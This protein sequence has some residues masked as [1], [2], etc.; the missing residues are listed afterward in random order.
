MQNPTKS[1]REEVEELR[2]EQGNRYAALKKAFAQSPAVI[3]RARD[4]REQLLIK[5]GETRLGGLPLRVSTFLPDGPWGHQEYKDDAEAIDDIA[6]RERFVSATPAGDPEVIAWTSTEVFQRG[7]AAASMIQ[8]ENELRYFWR[9]DREPLYAIVNRARELARDGTT[10]AFE[11][12]AT[13][14]QGELRKV[15]REN[16][17][18]KFEPQDFAPNPAWVTRAIAS[19][20][21][22]LADEIPPKWMPKLSHA[23]Q[24]HGLF[25]ARLKEYGCGAYGCVL[26]TL[27]DHTVLKVTTDTTEAEFA[28]DLAATL[29]VPI[30][31]D[32]RMVAQLRTLHKKRPVFLLW[33]ESAEDVGKMDDHPLITAQHRRAQAA[34]E[35]MYRT[36]TSSRGAITAWRESVRK[37]A[38][39]PDL[40]Y[41]ARGMLRVFDEQGIFFGDVHGGNVGRCVREGD[42]R[43]VIIDPG[44]VSVVK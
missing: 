28:R 6:G 39:D 20:Y 10:E 16:P 42:L 12:A 14:L 26:P 1:F 40:T 24:K 2:K 37:M 3:L 44:H 11:A 4:G 15:P 36:G 27:D 43:W 41:L 31:V 18:R 35:E 22:N 7:A 5:S 9:G 21:D 13:Y 29:I 33:R 32:Y 38:T 19:A 23:R 30:V 34:Y 25:I 17:Y 8:A